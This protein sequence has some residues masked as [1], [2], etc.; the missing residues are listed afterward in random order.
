[1]NFKIFIFN[2]VK[3]QLLEKKL[4]KNRKKFTRVK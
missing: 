3:N 1:M 2:F 4:Q